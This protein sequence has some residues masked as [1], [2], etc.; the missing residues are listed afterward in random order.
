MKTRS[1]FGAEFV[2][3]AVEDDYIVVKDVGHLT[4]CKSVTNDAEAV[5]ELIIKD[6]GDDFNNRKIYYIDSDEQLD[7][8]VHDG[9]KFT[10]FHFGAPE[11]VM[12]KHENY[13]W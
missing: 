13:Q 12:N 6:F 5:V 9:E 10:G 8:L 2:A 1:P 11:E 4:G 7:E 3:V